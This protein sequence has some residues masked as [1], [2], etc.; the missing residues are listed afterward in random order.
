VL[1]VGDL[2]VARASYPE[3]ISSSLSHPAIFTRS[4]LCNLDDN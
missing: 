1:Y 3:D 2:L 4:V